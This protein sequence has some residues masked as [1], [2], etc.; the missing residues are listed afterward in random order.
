M[1][2]K[3][4]SNIGKFFV[5]SLSQRRHFMTI[6]SIFFLTLP[7]TTAKQIGFYTALG[8]VASFLL[9]IPSGYFS[10]RFGHKNTL[11]L[12]K[13]LMILSTLAFIFA[14]GFVT[15]TIASVLIACAFALTS[16]TDRAF[17]HDTYIAL[18]KEKEYGVAMSRLIAYV[19]LISAFFIIALPLLT[20][21]SIRTPFVVALALDIAGL[22]AVLTLVTPPQ[23]VAVAQ[24]D[25]RQLGRVLRRAVKPGFYTTALFIGTIGGFLIAEGGYRWVYLE[26]LGFP[27]ILLG[28][29][30]GLSRF[31]WFAIGT[32]T[33]RFRHIPV[34]RL[35]QAELVLFPAALIMA[36]IL[37]N[38]YV[39]GIIFAATIGYFW[40]RNELYTHHF[41]SRFI[42]DKR[43]KATMLSVKH[44]VQAAIEIAVA[45]AIGF[46]MQRSYKLGYLTLGAALFTVLLV[47]YMRIPQDT[48]IR[49]KRQTKS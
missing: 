10:D 22:L 20:A 46:V 9:E 48:A 25:W 21:I 47:I 32:N 2:G 38:P 40:G 16:G 3:Y 18:R 15:F 49:T 1:R 33:Q 11:V 45:L 39:V 43:Y 44:Q 31:I 12:A 4:E 19:S 26:S 28:F 29:V 37:D 17:M 23:A 8:A 35:L 13:V 5:F 6:I 24:V 34:Q 36:A 14:S 30:N 42:V 41:L 27:I 7:D